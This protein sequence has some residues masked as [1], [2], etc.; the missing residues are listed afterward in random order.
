MAPARVEGAQAE[1]VRPDHDGQEQSRT[2]S[3]GRIRPN[4]V[5]LGGRVYAHVVPKLNVPATG[6]AVFIG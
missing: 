5:S 3:A 6:R 4:D 2:P 1:N